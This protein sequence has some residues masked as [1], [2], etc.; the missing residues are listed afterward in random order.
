MDGGLMKEFGEF[1]ASE[2]RK[3]VDA[4]LWESGIDDG[5][6]SVGFAAYEL[7]ADLQQWGR[8]YKS[9]A[10]ASPAETLYLLAS[11]GELHWSQSQRSIGSTPSGDD[12]NGVEAVDILALF[13]LFAFKS[14]ISPCYE[15]YGWS[16]EAAAALYIKHT[17]EAAKAL[18]YAM[19]LQVGM[20]LSQQEIAKLAIVKK[21]QNGARV[22]AE[23]YASIKTDMHRLARDNAPPSGQW[24]SRR[25]AVH[26]LLPHF[27]GHADFKAMS[28]SESQAERTLD[29]YLKEMP[30]ADTL[31]AG[32][33]S[34]RT[35]KRSTSAG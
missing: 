26:T 35:G 22:R 2:L 30:D 11:N 34:T 17:V 27:K 20:R 12:S 19:K 9:M 31:F 18:Q 3:V 7:A 24:K 8:H 16:P 21:A 1:V 15:H 29:G 4:D 25:N 6:D 32:R 5:I 33:S 14:L 23:K 10:F 28:M 13:G